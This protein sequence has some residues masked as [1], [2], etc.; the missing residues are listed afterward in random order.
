[1]AHRLA[2]ALV[3]VMVQ[4]RNDGGDQ[5]GRRRDP[6]RGT[7]VPRK[8]ANGLGPRRAP[9]ED[10]SSHH[11]YCPTKIDFGIMPWM[12]LVPSPACVTW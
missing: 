9:S 4:E 12:P 1:L 8:R 3:R 10:A 11:T 2:A 7:R 6:I 5:V